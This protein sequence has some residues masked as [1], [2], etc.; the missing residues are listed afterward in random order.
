LGTIPPHK[1]IDE[2]AAIVRAAGRTPVEEV[3]GD[4]QTLIVRLGTADGGTWHLVVDGS[5]PMPPI[6]LAPATLVMRLWRNHESGVLR[7]SL[8]LHGSEER[9]LFHCNAALERLVQRWLFGGEA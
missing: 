4:Y 7:G 6:P 3:V 8:Q 2:R 5:W 9:A 1:K